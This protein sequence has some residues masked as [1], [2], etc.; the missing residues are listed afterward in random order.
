MSFPVPLLYFE[1]CYRTGEQAPV[2]IGDRVRTFLFSR[3]FA[4]KT[5]PSAMFPRPLFQKFLKPSIIIAIN[6]TA[7]VEFLAR[8]QIK[9]CRV[10]KITRNREKSSLTYFKSPKPLST[11]QG[12]THQV[13]S[14]AKP[15][16]QQP[17][18]RRSQ[19]HNQ[20]LI[21]TIDATRAPPLLTAKGETDFLR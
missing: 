12:D 9:R 14:L 2:A 18:L 16:S 21:T 4:S 8:I 7:K 5:C 19:H 17:Q 3:S 11:L 10:D 6:E 20:S 13:Q 1:H 15:A